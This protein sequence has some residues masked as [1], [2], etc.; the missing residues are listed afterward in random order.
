MFLLNGHTFKVEAQQLIREKENQSLTV[1]YPE[2]QK[3]E[4]IDFPKEIEIIANQGGESTKIQIDYRSLEFNVETDFPFEI[5]S[6]YKEI[7]IE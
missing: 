1:T 5:P 2:Y 7:K 6:G 4:G 3:I